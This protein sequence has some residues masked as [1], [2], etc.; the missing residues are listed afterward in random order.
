MT[1]QEQIMN[2]MSR[3]TINQ[4]HADIQWAYGEAV[5]SALKTFN[6]AVA[7]ADTIRKEAIDSLII[8]TDKY[9]FFVDKNVSMA[10]Q[11]LL[12]DYT[13]KPVARGT[14]DPAGEL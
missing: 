6:E 8:E 14:F 4:V 3:A 11:Q 13:E 10:E 5:T 1:Y 2:S 9:C 12:F 7:Q